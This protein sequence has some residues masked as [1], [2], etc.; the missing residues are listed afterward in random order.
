MTNCPFCLDNKILKGQVLIDSD[1]CYF[2]ES[3]DPVLKCAGLIIPKRHVATPFDLTDQEWLAIKQM[4]NQVKQILDKENPDGYNLGFNVNEVGGQNVPH[5]HLHIIARFKDE[6]L[7]G[8]G[9]RYAFKQ[10]NNLRPQN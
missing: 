7:S 6:P 10:P 9:I 1:L 3:I 8:Q 2:V 5:T 4:I